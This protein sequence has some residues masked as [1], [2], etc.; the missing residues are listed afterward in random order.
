[1]RR[2]RGTSYGRS[3][4]NVM[5]REMQKFENRRFEQTGIRHQ[6]RQNPNPHESTCRTSPHSSFTT[7]L[8]YAIKEE[9]E[10]LGGSTI[11]ADSG[12]RHPAVKHIAVG[13][14]FSWHHFVSRA[15]ASTME[16]GRLIRAE[17]AILSQ[18]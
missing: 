8:G 2:E 15:G 7:I 13:M 1:M 4:R 9:L 10:P 11:L 14:Q 6:A 12:D 18:S 17:Q 3:A 5:P 16:L